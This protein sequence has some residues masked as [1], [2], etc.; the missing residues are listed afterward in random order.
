M[1]RN[2]WLQRVPWSIVWVAVI[3][4]LIGV[5]NLSSAAQATR[6]HL[7]L[8]Q[9]AFIG[10]SLVVGAGIVAV[11]T[12][13]LEYL[14]YP[15]FVVVNLLL[16]LVLVAGTTIKGSQRWLDLGFFNLQP[17]ELAK[18]AVI[19]AMA[20]YFSRYEVPGGYTLRGLL[21]PLNLSR[22]LGV[23]ALL[24]YR[25]VKQG[26]AYD[27]AVSQRLADLPPVDPIWLKVGAA[28]LVLGWGAVSLVVLA[29]NRFHHLDIIAPVDV[30]GLPFVL[31][32]IEPDLGTS[33]IVLAI[34]GLQV[35]FVG[36]TRNSLIIS[37]VMGVVTVVFGWS[38]LLKDYQKRRV[39]TF[40]H[41]ENDLQ[42]AGYHASQSMIAI[43]SGELTGKGHAAGTQT[44][45][46]SLPENHT[47]FVFSV[48]AEEWGFVGGTVL[49][50]L[51]LTLILLMLREARD[52]SDRFAVLVN[53]GAAAMIFLHVFI[54]IGMVTG[55]LPVV[56]A[57]LPFMSYGGS[58]MLTM[59]VAV[60]LAVNMRF[61]RG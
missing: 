4:S 46:S 10:V 40:L 9:L 33:L 47:D 59:M 22:P 53:V 31:V 6:P 13:L 36:V 49:I 37:F 39:D 57:T 35:L 54:N 41:P 2:H 18:I 45:L 58:S 3:I 7:Y 5:V 32:L 25:W 28:V 14:A 17:S 44:Q 48:L 20:R 16:G 34:A 1:D 8:I 29:K 52:F 26:A 19:L 27:A 61:H 43:G 30:M 12:R 11:P 56:G 60:A 15:V 23:L 50:L 51:F 42:G 24:I 38:F 21:R 55:I